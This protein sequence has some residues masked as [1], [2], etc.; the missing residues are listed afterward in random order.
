MDSLWTKLALTFTR[1]NSQ[2]AKRRAKPVSIEDLIGAA[3]SGRTVLRH[4]G[5]GAAGCLCA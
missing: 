3:A 5:T 4:R 2:K 1:S